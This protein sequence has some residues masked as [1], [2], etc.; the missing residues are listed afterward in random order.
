MIQERGKWAF[1]EKLS[2][3][4][5]TLQDGAREEQVLALAR[6]LLAAARAAGVTTLSGLLQFTNEWHRLSAA[7]CR[8]IQAAATPPAEKAAP[9]A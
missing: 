9:P 7:A 4:P 5:G 6:E 8:T 2:V 1:P 3:P